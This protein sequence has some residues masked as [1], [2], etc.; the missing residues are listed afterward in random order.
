MHRRAAENDQVP[1][2][3]RWNAK[4]LAGE[5]QPADPDPLL[6]ESCSSLAAGTA[7]DLAGGAGRHALWLARQGWQVVLTDISAEGLAIASRR[8]AEAEVPLTMRCE[9][10]EETIAWAGA[11]ARRFDLVVVFWFLAR[12][13]FPA[14]PE[15]LAPGGRLLYKTFT[16][17]NARFAGRKP[18]SFALRPGE[19]RTA[20]PGLET[21]LFREENGVAELVALR[22]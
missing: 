13:Q 1:D 3:E 11:A 9:S 16:A 22:P 10:V 7:L 14:L 15:L 6:V 18:P 17:D 5:A 12:E 21:A 20:F 8:A 4:Y 19:L 2:R